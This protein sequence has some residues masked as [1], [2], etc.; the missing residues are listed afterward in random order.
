MQ[1]LAPELQVRY[2]RVAPD[3]AQYKRRPL[4]ASKV[5]PRNSRFVFVA[6]TGRFYCL[7]MPVNSIFAFLLHNSIPLR[8]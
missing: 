3:T 7:M 6:K 2:L 5:V 1:P 4:A 8:T